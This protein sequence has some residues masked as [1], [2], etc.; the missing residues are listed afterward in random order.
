M[1]FGP[2]RTEPAVMTEERLSSFRFPEFTASIQSGNVHGTQV[3]T[4]N[5]N[6]N[7]GQHESQSQIAH[8]FHQSVFT[9]EGNSIISGEKS[10]RPIFKSSGPKHF[11]PSGRTGGPLRKKMRAV[12]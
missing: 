11:Q 1:G 3:T 5:K 7:V 8:G 2:R 12:V 10:R 9:S 6:M 4:T